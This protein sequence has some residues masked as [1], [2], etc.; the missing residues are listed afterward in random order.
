[1]DG[2]VE[3]TTVGSARVGF[4]V[5]GTGDLDIV[6]AAGLSSH[7]DVTMEQPRYRRYIE[8]LMA[9][10]RVIRFDRRGTG[11]SDAVPHDVE[12]T[13]ETWA[14]D[15]AAVLEATSSTRAVVIATNDAGPAAMLF[16]ATHPELIVGLVLFN[17][18]AR[19]LA[20]DDYPGHTAETADFVVQVLQDTWGS[21][22]SVAIVAPSLVSDAPFCRWYA[23][24]QRSACSPGEFAQS[25]R[26]VLNMDSRAVLPEVHCPTLVLHRKEYFTVPIEQGEALAS[27]IPGAEL[28]T[29]PGGDAPIWAQNMQE[30]TE[31]I[32]AFLGRAP[33]SQPDN[34]VFST[35]LFTDI[36]ESTQAAVEMGDHRWRQMIDAYDAVAHDAVE[37]HDGR[38]IKAT[39]DGT[40]A[41]FDRPTR[42]LQCAYELSE[43]AASLGLLLRSGV[44][45]GPIAIREDGDISGVAVHAAARVRDMAHA[46]EVLTSEVLVDLVTGDDFEFSPR[47]E[48]ELRGLD[49]TWPLYAVAPTS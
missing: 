43:R 26:R 13:W 42:A 9:Y 48:H 49:G 3:F 34:R 11:V 2:D 25:M 22:S 17:T 47:G 19:F 14:D 44:H 29:V 45:S 6:Y 10:G 32:G 20:D 5:H 18:T 12:P 39:G 7:L 41:T 8:E 35:V 36:V 40:L 15:L 24:F 30:S 16:A 38:F 46:N 28:A 27:L 1:M 21:E 37:N 31:R 23:R 4:A 33:A